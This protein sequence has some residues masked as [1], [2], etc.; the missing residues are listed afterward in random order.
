MR[1]AAYPELG[2]LRFIVVTIGKVVATT[3]YLRIE[4]GKE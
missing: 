1:G 3:N 2:L 4:N